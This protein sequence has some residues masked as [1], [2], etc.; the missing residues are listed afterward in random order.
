MS[1]GSY[2]PRTYYIVL[3]TRLACENCGPEMGSRSQLKVMAGLGTEFRHSYSLFQHNSHVLSQLVT[4]EEFASG[5]RTQPPLSPSL[6]FLEQVI[7]APV[8]GRLPVA[9]QAAQS[10]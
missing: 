2:Y 10:L 5:K 1:C 6:G 7:N 3:K 8:D 4:R 9:A